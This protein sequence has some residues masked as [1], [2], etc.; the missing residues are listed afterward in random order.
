MASSRRFQFTYSYERDLVRLPLKISIGSSGAPTIS[1]GKG[2]VSITRNSAG[3]YTL[4]L[5]D[6]FN[7]LMH[8]GMSIQ[9]SSAPAAP[10][11][12]VVSETVNSTKTI[13][14][15]CRDAAGVATDPAS[16]EK[17]MIE[18]VARNAST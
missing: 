12:H 15:Q 16:G 1:N 6:M 2:L 17:L 4:Q 5:K 9:S 8:V 14:I 11:M 13:V 7:V 18:V 3:N 10:I